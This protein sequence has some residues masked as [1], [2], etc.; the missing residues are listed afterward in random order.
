MM[1]LTSA[2]LLVVFT[3]CVTLAVAAPQQPQ[4]PIVGIVSEPVTHGECVSIYRSGL[5]VGDWNPLKTEKQLR[6]FQAQQQTA[7]PTRV[8]EANYSGCIWSLYV[9]WLEASGI[10][11]LPIPWDASNETLDSLLDGV[12]GVLLAG[13]IL[14]WV[15]SLHE[16][17]FKVAQRMYNNVMARNA[18]GDRL[19]LWGT[20]QGFE[21]INA[22]AAGT[23]DVVKHGYKGME[24]LMLSVNFTHWANESAMYGAAPSDVLGYMSQENTTL[25]WHM[26]GVPPSEYT[27]NTQLNA[28]GLRPLST[29]DD[30]T[31][32]AFVSSVES[33][34]A[35]IYAVQFHPERV[36]F[37]W[38]NDAIGHSRHA[39]EVS[40]YLSLFLLEQLR[41]SNHSFPTPQDAEQLLIANYQRFNLGWGVRIYNV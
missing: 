15:P 17:Y 24:P 38:D 11:V 5:G 37:Q 26:Y 39:I 33:S 8:P 16:A 23:F 10:R 1:K 32:R 6:E 2:S 31:G 19:V 36:M 29:T 35:A 27:D 18:R 13:G 9:D 7:A 21:M 40:Q 20:C 30:V 4:N 25:N 12:N 22:A 3:C 28:S 41:E 34:V 14:G